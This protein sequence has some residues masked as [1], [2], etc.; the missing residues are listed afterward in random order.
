MENMSP[1]TMDVL[2]GLFGE[3]YAYELMNFKIHSGGFFPDFVIIMHIKKGKS[4]GTYR[5]TELGCIRTVNNQS[6]F[7]ANDK[8]RKDR[9]RNELN[10]LVVVTFLELE[11]AAHRLT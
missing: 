11:L 10:K 4:S 1:R 6:R 8:A 3:L 9:L 5:D 2:I 7:L